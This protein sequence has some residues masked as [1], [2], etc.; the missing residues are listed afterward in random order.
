MNYSFLLAHTVI[1]ALC[2][3]ADGGRRSYAQMLDEEVFGP[4]GMRET[5]LGVRPD[6]A[7]RLCPVRA[8]YT[9][10][11]LIPAEAMG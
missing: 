1:A 11:G 4:L 3:R 2:Q 8:A 5:S 7:Q 10:Q 6:L 9:G